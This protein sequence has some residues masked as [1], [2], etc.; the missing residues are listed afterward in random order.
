ML[1]IVL[2]IFLIMTAGKKFSGAANIVIGCAVLLFAVTC[3]KDVPF[4]GTVFVL[5]GENIMNA[6]MANPAIKMILMLVGAALSAIGI[7]SLV[8]QGNVESGAPDKTSTTSN[9]SSTKDTL[10]SIKEA[11]DLLDS[12]AI[13]EEEFTKIKSKY[14]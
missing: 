5:P 8:K 1:G 13:T 9:Y 7:Y 6:K 11:K 14:L 3:F 10:S 12:G 2:I 4:I